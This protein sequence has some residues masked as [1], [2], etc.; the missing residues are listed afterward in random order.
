MKVGNHDAI[1][2]H[3][4]HNEDGLGSRNIR[5]ISRQSCH[6]EVGNVAAMNGLVQLLSHASHIAKSRLTPCYSVSALFFLHFFSG[7]V[8]WW[9]V[10][11]S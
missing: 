5:N 6:N 9:T 8:R 4:C 3:C 10:A 7:H 11:V 1:R 2:W